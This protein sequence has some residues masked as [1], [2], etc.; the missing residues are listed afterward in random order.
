MSKPIN[1]VRTQKVWTF[2]LF[3]TMLLKVQKSSHLT[4]KTGSN[5]VAQADLEFCFEDLSPDL[6]RKESRRT[7]D[8]WRYLDPDMKDSGQ[9]IALAW[10]I[11]YHSPGFR[12]NGEQG[13][14]WRPLKLRE[15]DCL[16]EV[17]GLTGEEAHIVFIGVSTDVRPEKDGLLTDAKKTV[18]H[19][20]EI[21][22]PPAL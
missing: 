20:V 17:A 14:S 21:I 2:S 3:E 11:T 13:F 9:E 15:G 10:L 16:E 4:H 12:F 7:T 18:S 22:R 1:G 19:L 8:A 5:I 6:V